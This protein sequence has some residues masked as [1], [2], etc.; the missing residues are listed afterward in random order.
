MP[1]QPT[2]TSGLE[3]VVHTTE[4]ST[5]QHFC[6]KLF[7]RKPKRLKKDGTPYK[8]RKGWG[9]YRSVPNER[10]AEFN[11]QLDVQALQ[12]EIHNLTSVRDI[13][14]SKALVQRYSP[15]GSLSRLANEYYKVFRTGRRTDDQEQRAFMYRIMD[16]EVEVGNGLCGP[17]VLLDQIERYSTYLR[18][19]STTGRVTNVIEADDLV[20][21][22]TEWE[23]TLQILRNT[24]EMIFPHIMSYKELVAQLV[25]ETVEARGRSVF[26]FNADGK[27]VKHVADL[28][29]AFVRLV[30]DPQLVDIL[31]GRARIQGNALIAI[32]DDISSP[33]VDEEKSAATLTTDECNGK[34]SRELQGE[35]SY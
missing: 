25:G 5:P 18:F 30:K 4:E 23:V 11:L 31:L 3:D 15:E 13:L 27:C 9:P 6:R 26:H 28:V 10:A 32:P 33:Y 24:I 19:I 34:A 29:D 12:Q 1:T 16:L 2:E 7:Q 35:S 8:P 22:S 20:L 14:S 17:D 21:V